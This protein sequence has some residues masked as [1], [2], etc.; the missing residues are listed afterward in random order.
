MSVSLLIITAVDS[1]LVISSPNVHLN[2]IPFIHALEDVG[3]E[4]R[5]HGL[6]CGSFVGF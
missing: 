3:P 6:S 1:E 4:C 5:P 2:F